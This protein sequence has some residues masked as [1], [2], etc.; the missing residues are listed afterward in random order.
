MFILKEQAAASGRQESGVKVDLIDPITRK[1]TGAWIR[2]AGV[3]SKRALEAR[4]LAVNHVI[5]ARDPSNRKGDLTPAEKEILAAMTL[6]H[7]IIEWGN[8]LE[9]EGGKELECNFENAMALLTQ[10]GWVQQD[11]DEAAGDQKNF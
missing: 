6:A 3:H 2:I 8:I 5:G 11:L 7:C 1:N 9:E 4:R 10:V